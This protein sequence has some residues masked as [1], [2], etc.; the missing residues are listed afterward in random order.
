M[1]VELTSSGVYHLLLS[2]D[3]YSWIEIS[4]KSLAE[5]LK[6][7]LTIHTNRE[8]GRTDILQMPIPK[9]DEAMAEFKLFV[10]EYDNGNALGKLKTIINRID[11][12]VAESF[13]ISC[14]EIAMIQE[15]M[16]LDAFLKNIKPSLPYTGKKKRG[17]LAGL[18]ES[19]RYA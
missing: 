17:L 14:D 2:D 15:Q 6:V 1:D 16:Q 12:I 11:E 5:R 7:A 3:L 8:L 18:G 10:Q 4:N 9:D 13:G 19:S